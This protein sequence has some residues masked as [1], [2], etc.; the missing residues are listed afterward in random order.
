MKCL[1]RIIT[2]TAFLIASLFQM[3]VQAFCQDDGN[4][5]GT[6]DFGFVSGGNHFVDGDGNIYSGV[7]Y[8]DLWGSEDCFFA[9]N[10]EKGDVLTFDWAVTSGAVTAGVSTQGFNLQKFVGGRSIGNESFDS[11]SIL[12]PETGFNHYSYVFEYSSLT[13]FSGELFAQDDTAYLAFQAFGYHPLPH[14]TAADVDHFLL[15][16]VEINTPSATVPSPAPIALILST[17]FFIRLKKLKL[18]KA[19]KSSNLS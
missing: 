14:E 16:N 7:D 13:D 1:K 4:G 18:N 19:E 8:I 10:W 3:Q 6:E 17:L 11:N 12:N 9:Y 5:G 2:T 15:A